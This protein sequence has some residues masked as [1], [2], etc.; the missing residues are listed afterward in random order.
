[1]NNNTFAALISIALF[2]MLVL[3]GPAQAINLALGNFSNNNP[4]LGEKI[5]TIASININANEFLNIK[6]ITLEI[7]GAENRYCIFNVSGTSIS[8]CDGISINLLSNLPYSYGYGYNLGYFYGYGYGYSGGNLSY[9]V[10]IFTENFSLGN[11]NFTLKIKSGSLTLNSIP[12][13]LNI[14][15]SIVPRLQT[16]QS[17]GG[18]GSPFINVSNKSLNSGNLTENKLINSSFFNQL[19]NPLASG[20]EES[21]NNNQDSKEEQDYESENNKEFSRITGAVAGLASE[22]PFWVITILIIV[23]GGAFLV[24][25]LKIKSRRLNYAESESFYP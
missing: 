18:G 5:S 22:S 24:I 11:Y 8:G 25:K 4:F 7:I 16:E 12:K 21:E 23:I 2:G 6:N 19:S 13:E 1:M 17:G 20:S 14:I 9:N 3:L 15:A 10:T